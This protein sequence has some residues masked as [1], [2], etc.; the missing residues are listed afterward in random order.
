[1]SIEHGPASD[2]TAPDAS[3]VDRIAQ[4]RDRTAL[5]SLQQRYDGVLSQLAYDMV[6]DSTV[7]ARA[8][9]AAFRHLWQFAK[10]VNGTQ[11][12][13]SSWLTNV[14]QTYARA[15]AV[16]GHVPVFMRSAVERWARLRNEFAGPLR[17]GAWYDVVSVSPE[18]I[19]VDVQQTPIA[20]PHGALDLVY[21]A[22]DRWTVVE[23]LKD[24]PS[25]VPAEFAQRY[26]VCPICQER[27]PV[28]DG[29]MVMGCRRCGGAYDVAWEEPDLRALAGWPARG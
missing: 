8:V 16:A 4:S 27:V 3:L 13:V 20:V 23:W 7:A 5:A 15:M 24:P 21:D 25:Q 17:R 2:V 14:T 11:V 1:M 6:F 28:R 18:E 9:A 29:H 12:N 22:P 26:A 19:V 10:E